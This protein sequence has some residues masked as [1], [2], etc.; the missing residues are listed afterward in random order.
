VL[1][2]LEGGA[3]VGGEDLPALLLS[4]ELPILNFLRGGFGNKLKRC[5]REKWT[6]L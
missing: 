3:G 5:S 6:D 4:V 2:W 1:G